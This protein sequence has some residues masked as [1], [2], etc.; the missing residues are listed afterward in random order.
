MKGEIV[1]T[2]LIL[3]FL[4]AESVSA[5][6]VGITPVY[7]KEFFKP[8]LE[9]EFTF[10]AFN[11]QPEKGINLYVQG[12]L[13]EYVTLSESYF[14]GDGEFTVS[15]KL[16]QKIDKPGK[17]K[18][19]IGAMEATSDSDAQTFGGIA[20]I[21]GRIDILVPYPGRYSESIFTIS[22]INEGE[23]A[24][25]EISTENLGTEELKVN[26]TIEIYKNNFTEKILTENIN[27]VILKSKETTKLIGTIDTKGLSPGEYQAQAIIDW[28]KKDKLNQTFQVGQFLV[29]I[30]DYDYLFEENKINKFNIEIQN[31]WNLKIDQ[32]FAEVDITEEGNLR[33]SFKTV[34]VD[35][36]PWES[37]NLTG[38]FDTTGL[39]IKRYTANIIL[40]YGGEVTSKLVAI[41]ITESPKKKYTQYIVAAIII[42]LIILATFIYLILKLR[43]LT[44]LNRKNARKK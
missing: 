11:T 36:N 31:K 14:L 26:Y 7:Y 44:R 9:K 20:A 40:N 3:S 29:E 1:F 27:R 39:E 37:K 4:F 43:K 10:H 2:I 33:N 30:T 21:Q 19:I 24:P 34:S 13:A 23:A 35:A 42:A 15:I 41:Y 17:H 25:Y 12:D 32:I 6:G 28:G 8:N 18:I 22:N 5:G 38:Y 16:P